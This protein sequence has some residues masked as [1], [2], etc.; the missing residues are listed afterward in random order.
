M[1]SRAHLLER[2]ALNADELP[3]IAHFGG[4][5]HWMLI[6]TDRIVM[7]RESGLQSMPWSDL[8]NATTDTAHVHAA[9][10]SGV[11]GKLSLSRLRLQR[12]DAEDIEFEVEAGPAFFGLWNVLKTIASLRKE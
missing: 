10:S 11:G 6:T 7:G 8:E 4:P 12:R 5:A 2:A 3:V 9:F 1:D